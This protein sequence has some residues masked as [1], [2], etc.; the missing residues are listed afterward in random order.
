MLKT[1]LCLIKLNEAE[2]EIHLEKK[3]LNYVEADCSDWYHYSLNSLYSFI[4]VLLKFYMLIY[5]LLKGVK[6][7]FVGYWQCLYNSQI[8]LTKIENV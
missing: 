1:F 4:T 7:L 8:S 3:M 6:S 5:M 2:R